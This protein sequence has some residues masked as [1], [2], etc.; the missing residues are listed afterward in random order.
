MGI[1]KNFFL[2]ITNIHRTILNTI[3][4]R[5]RRFRV[6]GRKYIFNIRP[7]KKFQ[8]FLRGEYL[9]KKLK[10]YQQNM[11]KRGLGLEDIKRLYFLSSYI[12][13][14]SDRIEDLTGS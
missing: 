11:F 7:L 5:L 8:H 14:Q 10:K 2:W 4:V 12:I 9:K 3:F 1:I 6:R 13:H